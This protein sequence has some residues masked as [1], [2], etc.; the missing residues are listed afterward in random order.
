MIS[1]IELTVGIRLRCAA[2]LPKL[3][4]AEFCMSTNLNNREA[5]IFIHTK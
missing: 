1:S 4:K 2:P 3:D 5:C